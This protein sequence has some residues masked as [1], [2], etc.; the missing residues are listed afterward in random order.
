[1]LFEHDRR[2]CHLSGRDATYEFWLK[3]GIVLLGARFL[4]VCLDCACEDKLTRGASQNGFGGLIH[5]ER[6]HHAKRT[7]TRA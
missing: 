5:A 2:P 7:S 6:Q 1:M 4:I 3:A